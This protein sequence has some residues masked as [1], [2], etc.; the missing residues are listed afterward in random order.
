MNR[1]VLLSLLALDA[2]NRGYGQNVLLNPSDSTVS[3][4]EA[5][6][7]LGNATILNVDLPQGSQ[8]VGFYAISY[9]WNGETIISYRGTNFPSSLEGFIDF[10]NQNFIGGWSIF[11]GFGTHTHTQFA[12]DFYTA[13]TGQDFLD[14]QVD[15][16]PLNV[17]VTGHSLGGGLAGYISSRTLASAEVFDPVPFGV[18]AWRSAISDA[19]AATVAEFFGNLSPDEVFDNIPEIVLE[20]LMPGTSQTWQLFADR[21]AQNI[22]DRAPEFVQVYGSSLEGEIAS[23]IQNL[24]LA[25]GGVL[26]SLGPRVE[27]ARL[28]I[29]H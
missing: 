29:A 12:R 23:L 18:F 22:A 13:V 21:L 8:E 9:E 20:A 28:T 16:G 26:A 6:R 10:L 4:N 19:L 24:Q 7:Q 1:E 15:P 14:N 5:G 11:T 25:V 2:Y 3:Q 17:T 27:R